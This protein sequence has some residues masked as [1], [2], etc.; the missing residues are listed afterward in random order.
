[1]VGVARLVQ[2]RVA[3]LGQHEHATVVGRDAGER[4][5]EREEEGLA[6]RGVEAVGGGVV[7][8]RQAKVAAQIRVARD[9]RGILRGRLPPPLIVGVLRGGWLLEGV[10]K[11]GRLENQLL[12]A[13]SGPGLRQQNVAQEAHAPL[14]DQPRLV[15]HVQEAGRKA[16]LLEAREHAPQ[17]GERRLVVVARKEGGALQV[18]SPVEGAAQRGGRRESACAAMV[19]AHDVEPELGSLVLPKVEVEERRR[20][21]GARG[22]GALDDILQKGLDQYRCR[23]GQ[24]LVCLA[25]V[26]GGLVL[27]AR[28]VDGKWHEDVV[29]GSKA[30]LELLL[31]CEH[32]RRS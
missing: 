23:G 28:R 17:R 8:V 14:E 10:R 12:H 1:V 24:I 30:M 26:G 2:Q 15:K 3:V 22:S 25:P 13:A 16:E 4:A 11:D 29:F 21:T 6:R 19:G 31:G 9:L 32:E 20:R 27:V 18:P 5:P 7:A